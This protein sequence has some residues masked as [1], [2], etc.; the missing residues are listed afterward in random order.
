MK[1]LNSKEAIYGAIIVVLGCIW[2]KVFW[3]KRKP[4]LYSLRWYVHICLNIN[5]FLKIA[6]NK[7]PNDS[8]KR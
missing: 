8:D 6:A 1:F 4:K 3:N 7:N 2:Y 5:T